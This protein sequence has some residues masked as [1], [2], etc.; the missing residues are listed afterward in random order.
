MPPILNAQSVTKQFGAKPLFKDISLTVEDGE[1]YALMGPNGSGKST[2]LRMIAGIYNSNSGKITKQG[3][4]ISIINLGAGLKERLTMRE[5]IFL[6]GSL[7]GMSQKDIRENFI[8]IVNLSELN[9]FVQTKIYQFSSGMVQRLAF[10]IAVHS[11][12]VYYC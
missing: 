5:N 8:S 10:S 2:L 1:F 9:N 6:V 7:F 12:P 3:K 4:I 11:K